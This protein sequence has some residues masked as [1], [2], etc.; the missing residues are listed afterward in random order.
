MMQCFPCVF[1]KMVY[2]LEVASDRVL[3]IQLVAFPE[4]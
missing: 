4:I 3:E 2:S 1:T